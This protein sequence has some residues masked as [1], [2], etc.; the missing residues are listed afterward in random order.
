[1]ATI[2][3]SDIDRK[4][5]YL[6]QTK[7][8][9]RSAI[10]SKGQ[11]IED[12]TTFRE[13]ASIINNIPSGSF[14]NNTILGNI[15]IDSDNID[16]L[17]NMTTICTCDNTDITNIKIG[18]Y[19]KLNAT[20]NNGVNVVCI[21]KILNISNNTDTTSNVE[22]NILMANIDTSDATATAEDI[23]I[24]KTAYINDNKVTGTYT[25]V[26]TQEDYENAITLLNNILREEYNG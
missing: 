1:M 19:A 12:R 15:N 25:D 24:N 5:N 22:C 14:H 23:R 26:I 13:Y 3:Q 11:V 7:Q 9:I 4:L 20:I 10:E 21:V 16:N 17:V 8:D 6:N 2:E 18:D